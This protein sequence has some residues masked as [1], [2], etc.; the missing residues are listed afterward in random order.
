MELVCILIVVGFYKFIY[1]MFSELYTDTQR[2]ETKKSV[3]LH[4]SF[5]KKLVITRLENS[6]AYKYIKPKYQ[7][8]I[9]ALCVVSCFNNYLLSLVV[10]ALVGYIF[11]LASVKQAGAWLKVEPA[12]FGLPTVARFNLKGHQR[13]HMLLRSRVWILTSFCF[14]L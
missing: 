14:F 11:T 7:I 4:R 8:I 5:K 13:T 12:P 3:Y 10:S 2:K 9:L 6:W 1:V